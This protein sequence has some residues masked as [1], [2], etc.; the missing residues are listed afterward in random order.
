MTCEQA[1]AL[2]LE[3]D[4][5]ELAGLGESE[6]TSHLA[7]CAAC[8]ERAR[9]IVAAE[10]ALGRVLDDVRPRAG[11]GRRSGSSRPTGRGWRYIR[12][13]WV[14]LALA[15]GVGAL[16]LIPGGEPPPEPVAPIA[17]E[18]A[19]SRLRVDVPAGRSA[20]LYETDNPDV[21]VVWFY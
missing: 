20:V 12:K 21:I 10:Q 8:R 4:L 19:A 5:T 13:V 2:M 7:E 3:A 18:A 9:R 1:T 6:L 11:V 14:P 16:M 15:A 17:A